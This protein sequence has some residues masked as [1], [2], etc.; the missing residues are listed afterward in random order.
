[1][2]RSKVNQLLRVLLN[3]GL[4]LTAPESREKLRDGFS[5]RLDDLGDRASRTYDEAMDRLDRAARAVRGEHSSGMESVIG[6]LAGVGVGVGLGILFAPASGEETRAALGDRIQG[7]QNRASSMARE[8][9]RS[10]GT[11][12]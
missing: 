3:A 5:D 6:F 1:M 2:A 10:T 12:G 8:V 9:R 4:L 11:E 7:V